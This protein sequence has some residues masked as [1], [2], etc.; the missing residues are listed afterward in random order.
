LERGKANFW[1]FLKLWIRNPKP[2]SPLFYTLLGMPLILIDKLWQN[3][4]IG[5][6]LLKQ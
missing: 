4:K 3:I 1:E 6:A 5:K 2:F